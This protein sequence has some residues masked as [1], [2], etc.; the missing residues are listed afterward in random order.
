[1]FEVAKAFNQP[2]GDWKVSKGTM[3]SSMFVSAEAFNQPMGDWDFSNPAFEKKKGWP[4]YGAVSFDADNFTKKTNW[5]R[6]KNALIAL[7]DIP[8]H[9]V[10]SIPE[11]KK[12]IICCL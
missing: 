7:N 4:F 6:R 10:F 12:M 3:R 9:D 5:S 11:M 1:M 2:L 8:I